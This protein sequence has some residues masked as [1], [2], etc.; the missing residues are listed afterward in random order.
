[1]MRGYS[2]WDGVEPRRR[3]TMRAAGAD[4]RAVLELINE[5]LD[6]ETGTA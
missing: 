2:D 5:N 6:D 3:A 1:V 4:T